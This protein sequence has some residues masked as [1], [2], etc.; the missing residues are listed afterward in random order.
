MENR[1]EGKSK[2]TLYHYIV[3]HP[4]R[5]IAAN[6]FPRPEILDPGVHTDIRALVWTARRMPFIGQSR[7]QFSSPHEAFQY[8]HV[9]TTPTV[10]ACLVVSRSKWPSQAEVSK[11][12]AAIPSLIVV[13]NDAIADTRKTSMSRFTSIVRSTEQMNERMPAD[14]TDGCGTWTAE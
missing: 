1:K 3:A 10:H 2:Q 11:A 5:G 13:K 8:I 4:N 14:G 9:Y 12:H 7:V 6:A